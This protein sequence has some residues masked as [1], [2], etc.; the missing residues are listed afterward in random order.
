MSEL[1]E[2]PAP[3]TVN[4]QPGVVADM[5]VQQGGGNKNAHG[6]DVGT[7]G[8][9]DWSFGLFGC[10]QEMS[11]CCL[12]CWCPCVMYGKNKQRLHHL[13]HQG[14]PHPEHGEAFSSDCFVYGCINGCAGLGCLLQ[15]GTRKETRDR[16]G[17]RGGFGDQC[18]GSCLCGICG[19]VQESREIDGEEQSLYAQRAGQP[20]P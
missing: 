10:F 13:Q 14:T 20:E 18:L 8:K 7:D 2:M 3:P 17:I 15:F 19:L 5:K 16:Y 11:T 1:K 9:R 12:A 6:M 4:Y